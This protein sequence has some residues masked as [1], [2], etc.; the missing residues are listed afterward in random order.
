[1]N[2]KKQLMKMVLDVKQSHITEVVDVPCLPRNISK[3]TKPNKDDVI[4]KTHLEDE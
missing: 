2:K 3:K 1:M 4:K